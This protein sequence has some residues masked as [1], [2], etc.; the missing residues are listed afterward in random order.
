MGDPFRHCLVADV[1]GRALCRCRKFLDFILVGFV[2]GTIRGT[3]AALGLLDRNSAEPVL[4]NTS[5]VSRCLGSKDSKMPSSSY[6]S[7]GCGFESRRACHR[8]PCPAGV[9]LVE[10][11]D[12]CRVAPKILGKIL[13][14]HLLFGSGQEFLGRLT[15]SRVSPQYLR[16]VT[17][18]GSSTERY[19]D[20]QS[21]GQG[22][23]SSQLRGERFPGTSGI[24]GVSGRMGSDRE[25]MLGISVGI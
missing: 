6:G 22:F 3:E 20:W 7:G 15:S 25:Q 18:L 10:V 5:R 13:V 1:S 23:E 4:C 8:N 9:S 24:A 17:R 12:C 19:H 16:C 2:K 21:R 11:W 14:Q